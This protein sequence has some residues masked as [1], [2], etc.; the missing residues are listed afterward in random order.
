MD[1][2]STSS[3]FVG[4]TKQNVRASAW[5]SALSAVIIG[6]TGASAIHL[7]VV[8]APLA[9]IWW[10]LPLSASL[11]SLVV[12]ATTMALGR[13]KQ[14]G[15][16]ATFLTGAYLVSGPS[17]AALNLSSLLSLGGRPPVWVGYLML[18]L[19]LGSAWIYYR[20]LNDSDEERDAGYPQGSF[21]WTA[22]P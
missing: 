8:L 13:T 22:I 20:S 11:A 18:V 6:G 10:V 14:S 5:V 12:L 16:Q 9:Q 19:S 17:M 1:S 2:N 21:I 3:K 15:R 4:C 7:S